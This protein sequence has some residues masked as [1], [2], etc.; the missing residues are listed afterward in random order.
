MDRKKL[1]HRDL[2]LIDFKA[3]SSENGEPIIEGYFAVFNSP[4][5]LWDGAYESIAP[6]AFKNTL[7]RDIRALYNHNDDI[8]LGRTKNNTLELREDEKGLFGVIKI[9]PNDTQAMDAY[10]RVKRGDVD[11]CSFGFEIVSEE[12]EKTDEQIHWTIKEVLLYEVSPCVFPAYEDT[13]VSARKSDFSD[14]QKR[15]TEY[16]QKTMKE[17]LKGLTE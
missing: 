7:N 6:G 17:R 11:Q 4:Y 2:R 16:W 8:V 3:R 9:N 14:I 5:K 12:F 1:Q 13:T 10:E 15:Q